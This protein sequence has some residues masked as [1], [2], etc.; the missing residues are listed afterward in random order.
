MGIWARNIRVKY[1]RTDLYVWERR[2][3]KYMKE[4]GVYVFRDKTIRLST[5]VRQEI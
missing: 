2:I 4:S 5:L 3:L 1:E